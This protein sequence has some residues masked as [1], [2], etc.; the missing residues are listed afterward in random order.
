MGHDYIEYDG[1]FE[2]FHD[3]D[4]W[5]LRHFLLAEARSMC[6]LKQADQEVIQDLYRHIKGWDWLEPGVWLGLDLSLFVLGQEERRALLEEVLDRAAEWIEA[7]GE[8]IPLNYL[9][10]HVDTP[11]AY[12][13]AAEPNGR[14]IEAI[15]RIRRMLLVRPDPCGEAGGAKTVD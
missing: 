13:T 2:Q 3:M 14:I 5:T 10:L 6:L 12:H 4:I 9:K 7:F 1:R 11:V 15:S 8:E